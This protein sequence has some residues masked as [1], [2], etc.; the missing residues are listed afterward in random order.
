MLGSSEWQTNAIVRTAVTGL[1]NYVVYDLDD[2]QLEP[3]RKAVGRD[4]ELL[5]RFDAAYVSP[6]SGMH[7]PSVFWTSASIDDAVATQFAEEFDLDSA[8]DFPSDLMPQLLRL[9]LLNPV[10]RIYVVWFCPE[11]AYLQAHAMDDERVSDMVNEVMLAHVGVLPS[12]TLNVCLKDCLYP[13]DYRTLFQRHGI[14]R[15]THASYLAKRHQKRDRDDDDDVDDR[16]MVRKA[17][18]EYQLTFVRTVELFLKGKPYELMVQLCREGRVEPMEAL[19]DLMDSVDLR[20]LAIIAHAFDQED[21]L[22]WIGAQERRTVVRPMDVATTVHPAGDALEMLYLKGLTSTM[23]YIRSNFVGI[24]LPP[25]MDLPCGGPCRWTQGVLDACS[26]RDY[27]LYRDIASVCIKYRLYEHLVWAVGRV[28]KPA[29]VMDLYGKAVGTGDRES[30]R[31]IS[32]NWEV[33]W[34]HGPPPEH[35][36]HSGMYAQ[37]FSDALRIIQST[38]DRTELRRMMKRELSVDFDFECD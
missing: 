17:P 11:D 3:V 29:H 18:N 8:V 5:E 28:T 6:A 10:L 37:G 36:F 21:I 7:E 23:E 1:K 38:D 34:S 19:V 13:A 26:M 2:D 24:A 30:M 16:A 15:E 31:L 35:D 4:T 20:R 25:C 22:E 33:S 32:D 14:A 27:D 12:D 9:C